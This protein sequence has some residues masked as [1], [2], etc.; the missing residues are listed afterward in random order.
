VE[1]HNDT[2]LAH[3]VV[4]AVVTF[5]RGGV[6]TW[7]G[8]QP[9]ADQDADPF[10]AAH[11]FAAPTLQA[12]DLTPM[13]EALGRVLELVDRR[14]QRMRLD[15]VHY[16]R[17]QICLLTDGWPSDEWAHLPS[18]LAEDA[19]HKRYRLFAVGIGNIGEQGREVL[20]AFAPVF[21]AELDDFRFLELL[22]F[23]SASADNARRNGGDDPLANRWEHLVRKGKPDGPRPA[24]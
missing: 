3:A 8:P 22:Q 16:A 1:L 18:R 11:A 12:D 2:N 10:V 9:L 15:G 17:P 7:R 19:T 21:N 14:K 20:K 13:G 24:W 6:T 23:M 5:G 4:V